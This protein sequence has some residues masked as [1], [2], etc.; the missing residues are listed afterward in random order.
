MSQCLSIAI[1]FRVPSPINQEVMSVMMNPGLVQQ[2]P[3]TPTNLKP[4]HSQQEILNAL[5]KQ[6]TNNPGMAAALMSQAGR[7]MARSPIPQMGDGTKPSPPQ[8]GLL[9]QPPSTP[10]GA[11]PLPGGK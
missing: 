1:I 11:S 6:A 3:T 2:E 10:R 8:L 9:P 7:D 4:P 5:V